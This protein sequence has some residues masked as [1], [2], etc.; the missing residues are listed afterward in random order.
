MFKDGRCLICNY[1]TNERRAIEAIYPNKKHFSKTGALQLKTKPYN[2]T[3]NNCNL[4]TT[5]SII[6]SDTCSGS[7]TGSDCNSGDC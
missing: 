1:I 5:A 2:T 4:I 6:I 3:I 7:N